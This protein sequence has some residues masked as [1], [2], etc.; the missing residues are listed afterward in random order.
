M[1]S[2]PLTP[3]EEALLKELQ[4]RANDSDVPVSYTEAEGR[5]IVGNILKRLRTEQ[6][7][8]QNDMAHKLGIS[9]Q[10]LSM[11]ENGKVRIAFD[12][13]PAYADAYSEYVQLRSA[14]IMLL[15]QDCWREMSYHIEFAGGDCGGYENETIIWIDNNK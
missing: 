6:N 11:V 12:K 3:E 7:I 9:P 14:M 8:Q 15:Y 2:K 1:P 13:V 4:A 5:V 10:Y